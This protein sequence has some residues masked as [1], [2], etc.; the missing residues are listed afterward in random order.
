MFIVFFASSKLTKSAKIDEVGLEAVRQR[1]A[2]AGAVAGPW[3]R[4]P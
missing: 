1:A 4:L 3:T 2:R